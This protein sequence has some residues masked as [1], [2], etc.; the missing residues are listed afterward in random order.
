VFR[1]V[2]AVAASA[3]KK[4]STAAPT[5][6]APEHRREAGG[7][8]QQVALAQ[9]HLETLGQPQRL[10]YERPVSRKLR[11]RAEISASSA[12]SSWLMRLGATRADDRRPV[13][14]VP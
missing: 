11:W 3:G 7:D 14:G 13:A 12:R 9:R 4:A 6:A 10:G 2:A 1:S 8:K 5:A